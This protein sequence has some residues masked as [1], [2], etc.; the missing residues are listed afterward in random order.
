MKKRFLQAGKSICYLFLFLGAQ[1]AASICCSQNLWRSAKSHGFFS[2]E[3]LQLLCQRLCSNHSTGAAMA[4]IS[5]AEQN[6]EKSIAAEQNSPSDDPAAPSAC[7]R[8]GISYKWSPA[9][10]A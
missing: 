3:R 5:L 1:M 9:T 8:Y 10:S 4:G 7:G 6:H 2:G